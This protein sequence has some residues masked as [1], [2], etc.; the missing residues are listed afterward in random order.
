MRKKILLFD[1]DYTLFDTAHFKESNLS[2]YLL[3]PDVENV[4]LKLHSKIQLGILSQ[5]E[6]DFQ[7]AKLKNTGIF[8]F[9]KSEYIFI[10]EDKHGELQ[11]IMKFLKDFDVIF[12]EDKKEMLERAKEFDPEIKTVWVQKGP[13]ADATSSKFSPHFTIFDISELPPLLEK[14]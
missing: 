10:V 7:I 5:G 6:H 11:H 12:V 1:I 4:L 8:N 13:Y 3:Y 2:S 9:F 14:L